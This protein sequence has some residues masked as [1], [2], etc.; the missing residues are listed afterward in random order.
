MTRFTDAKGNNILLCDHCRHDMTAGDGAFSLSPSKVGDGFISRDYDKGEIVICAT[1]AEQ[2]SQ[3]VV[4]L[5]SIA[6]KG[7]FT[8]SLGIDKT[9]V[10]LL[11]PR[12]TD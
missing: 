2:L 12:T 7:T 8:R 3:L 11:Q 6:V 1:C 9:Q 4:L 10:A 5:S